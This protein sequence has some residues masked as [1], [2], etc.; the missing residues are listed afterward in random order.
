VWAWVGMFGPVCSPCQI[1]L[2]MTYHWWGKKKV[3]RFSKF[4][5]DMIFIGEVIHWNPHWRAHLMLFLKPC[6][7]LCY[8]SG[9]LLGFMASLWRWYHDTSC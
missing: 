3:K 7:P 1:G 6:D 8:P 4:D 9:S 5:C 2:T